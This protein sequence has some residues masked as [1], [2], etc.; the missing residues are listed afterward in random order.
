MSESQGHPPG[1]LYALEDAIGYDPDPDLIE[2]QDQDDEP[3]LPGG[4][5]GACETCLSSEET[6]PDVMDAQCEY[7]GRY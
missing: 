4:C 7:G 5:G 6:D 3:E 1:D 2:D